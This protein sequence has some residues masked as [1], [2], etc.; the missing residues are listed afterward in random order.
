M[1][2]TCKLGSLCV[3][4]ALALLAGSCGKRSETPVAA[5]SAKPATES[6]AVEFGKLKGKW[7]R[8]DGDYVLEIRTLL[9]GGALEVGYFNPAPS[10]R[11]RR[12]STKNAG[13]PNSSSSFKT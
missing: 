7:G 12:S 5:T 6:V 3:G 9:D 10:M 8:P 4:A 1:T 13:S 2:T 11:A